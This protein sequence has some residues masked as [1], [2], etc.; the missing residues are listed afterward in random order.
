MCLRRPGGKTIGITTPA[1]SSSTFWLMG[2]RPTHRRGSRIVEGC[3]G[4]MLDVAGSAP[5]RG[6][7][8]NVTGQNGAVKPS[9]AECR[10]AHPSCA[11][12]ASGVSSSMAR[13]GVRGA[14]RMCSAGLPSM[15][16]NLGRTRVR[17]AARESWRRSPRRRRLHQHV[18]RAG[19]RQGVP[20]V[21]SLAAVNEA[22]QQAGGALMRTVP[23]GPPRRAFTGP[24]MPDGSPAS[25]QV[26]RAAPR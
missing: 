24:D 25:R 16:E 9:A 8:R 12:M 22:H 23:A 4:S 15:G 1:H 13:A 7:A 14:G 20:S 18:R 2:G 19:N 17:P 3:V 6:W 26:R 10:L 5:D 11:S 21:T